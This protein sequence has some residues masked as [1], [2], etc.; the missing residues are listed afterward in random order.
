M[1]AV[2]LAACVE[3]TALDVDD[4]L[5]RVGIL[6]GVDKL[7]MILI[8]WVCKKM[9]AFGVARI[10]VRHRAAGKKVQRIVVRAAILC[11]CISCTGIYMAS[12]CKIEFVM[13]CRIAVDGQ[14]RI[15]S[16]RGCTGRCHILVFSGVLEAISIDDELRRSRH[17][18]PGERT[19]RRT[20]AEFIIPARTNDGGRVI[21][22]RKSLTCVE[23][24]C[25]RIDIVCGKSG[26]PCSQA[27]DFDFVPVERLCRIFC[28]YVQH[29]I[30]GTHC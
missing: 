28:V 13:I 19:C 14:S 25:R 2:E 4:V 23:G 30:A 29:R 27:C 17:R 11:V 3:R 8:L 21:I 1:S 26:S 22:E 9:H 24:K 10:A 12:S 15:R 5:L 7:R 20:F 16:A 6:G 18:R